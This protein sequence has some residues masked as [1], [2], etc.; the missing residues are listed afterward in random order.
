[1][2]S[3]R[4]TRQGRQRS[5][6]TITVGT[7]TLVAGKVRVPVSTTGT[8]LAAYT[9]FNVHLRWDQAVFS[10]SS[11]NS[12]GTVIAGALCP[13][14]VPDAD[15]AGVTFACTSVGGAG[16]TAPGL[17]AT[18]VLTPTGAGCSPLH[19]FTYG[20]ADGGNASTGTYTIDATTHTPQPLTTIDARVGQSGAPC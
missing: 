6:P 5:A 3:A 16:T 15:G 2:P 17:L 1:M 8:G 10:F 19:L 4:Q 12:T 7:P 20:G 18:I 11:A 9:G 14:A 13:A